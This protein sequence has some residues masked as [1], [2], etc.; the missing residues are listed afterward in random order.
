VDWWSVLGIV[1]GSL[2]TVLCLANSAHGRRFFKNS[3][4]KSDGS[5]LQPL[6]TIPRTVR[7][8]V[9]QLWRWWP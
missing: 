2:V 9:A 6:A 1:V 8:D 5:K 3:W 7:G 4:G